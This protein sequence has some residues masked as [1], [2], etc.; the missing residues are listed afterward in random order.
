MAQSVEQLIIH[1]SRQILYTYFV[2]N[3][4]DYLFSLMAEDIVFI[5]TGKYLKSEG[6]EATCQLFAAGKKQMFPCIMSE[7]RY[8]ARPLGLNYWFCEAEGDLETHPG[9][10]LFFHECQRTTFIYRRNA[11]ASSG[12]GWELLHLN[13]S[14][15]WK[16]IQPQELFA[17]SNGQKNYTLLRQQIEEKMQD[18]NFTAREKEILQLIIRGL[19]NR[20]ISE[21]LCI[22]EVTVKKN[23]SNLYKKTGVRSRAN[24]IHY[25]TEYL[26]F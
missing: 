16:Q 21:A 7:E 26:N 8:I 6:R 25:L 9:Q 22:A 13:N 15:A 5:G 20:E 18:Y 23:L 14:M 24:L 3:R 11:K 12:L 10:T 17:Q 1:I 2:E 19:S 4:Q